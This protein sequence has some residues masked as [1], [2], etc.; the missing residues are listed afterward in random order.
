MRWIGEILTAAP[1]L[2]SSCSL[3]TI[4]SEFLGIVQVINYLARLSEDVRVVRT[5]A[6]NTSSMV[7]L[8]MKE[9]TLRVLLT[10]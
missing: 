1:K 10:T 3:D 2:A 8:S 7:I 4:Q 6:Q 5:T 9:K